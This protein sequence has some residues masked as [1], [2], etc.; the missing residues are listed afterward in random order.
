MVNYPVPVPGMHKKK[1]VMF[2]VQSW[3]TNEDSIIYICV[4]SFYIVCKNCAGGGD[5]NIH[6]L[7]V[8]VLLPSIQI[9]INQV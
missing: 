9:S 6:K 4:C 5:F 1:L 2:N 7:Q 8:L 3:K